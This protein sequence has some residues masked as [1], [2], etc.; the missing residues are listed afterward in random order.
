MVANLSKTRMTMPSHSS[1]HAPLESVAVPGLHWKNPYI[2]QPLDCR[3]ETQ[4]AVNQRDKM[5][6]NLLSGVCLACLLVGNAFG[7][8]DPQLTQWYNDHAA[9]NIGAAGFGNL[10]TA[11]AFKRSQWTGLNKSVETTLLNINGQ[12]GFVPGA[13]GIQ[14]YDDQIGNEKNTMI[15]LG[16]AYQL[17]V[18]ANGT[19]IG[20]GLSASMFSKSYEV[21]W[22][23]VD[24]LATP[25]TV[26][27]VIPSPNN[28]AGNSIDADFG[29]FVRKGNDYYAG[30]SV[31]HLAEQ[32]LS[33]LE[34]L[35]TRHFYFT[36][37]YNYGLSGDDLILR[38]NLMAKSDLIATSLDLNVN[39][40]ANDVVMNDLG[41]WAGVTWRAGDA[42]APAAGVEYRMSSKGAY[43]SSDQL[44]RLGYSYDMTTSALNTFVAGTHEVFVS[45][46]FKFTSTPPETKYANP[47]F[48]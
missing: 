1:L 9:Y 2:S 38:S 7:Q 41:A 25:W 22:F 15:K 21:D 26:D 5:I 4:P 36:G 6:R 29:V 20:I 37:G 31:T 24:G 27:G 28:A 3:L 35:S 30:L 33:S 8:Q 45:Y 18:L 40:L 48:L 12:L 32:S 23:A 16:Y 43:Q 46:A 10:T 42:I 17:P 14:F 47:R 11:T 13:V 19:Q 44:F 34:I 39:V